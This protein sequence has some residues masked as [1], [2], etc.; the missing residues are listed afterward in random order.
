MTHK[1]FI[2]GFELFDTEVPVVEILLLCK[3]GQD[4]LLDAIIQLL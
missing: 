2:Q 3:S 1:E 4:L